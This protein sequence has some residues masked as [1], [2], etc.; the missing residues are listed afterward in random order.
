MFGFRI[1][2]S[3]TSSRRG[4]LSGLAATVLIGLM[5]VTGAAQAQVRQT[6][7]GPVKGFTFLGF[8]QFR[9][10]PYAAP[11]IGKLRWRPPALPVAWKGTRDAT[12]YGPACD[13]PYALDPTSEDC[14]TLN[15]YQPAGVS[16]SGKLPVMIWI[17][18][19]AFITG[20]GRDF[21]GSAL[22][23]HENLTVVTINY[24][25]GYLGFL[26][27]PALSAADRNHVSGNYGLLD[28]QAA[29]AWVR[30]N[31]AAFG[32]DPGHI[33]IFGES[34]G[35]Q[36]V[37][38]QLISPTAGPLSGAIAQSGSY[39][40]TLPTLAAAEVSGKTAATS[41]GCPSQSLSC[42]Y[43]L[44]ASAIAAALNPLSNAGVSPVVDGRTLLSGPAQ[45]FAQGKFQH[46]PVINGSTHDE[47]RLFTGIER[48]LGNTKPLT[49]TQYVSTVNG[50]F[51]ALAATVLKAYPS[52]SYAIPDYAYDAVLTDVAFVCNTHLL[53]TLMARYT[54][55]YEYELADPNAPVA[56]GPVVSGFSYGSPHSADIS[57]LF[58]GYNVAFFHPKG[59]PALSPNQQILR[60]AIQSYWGGM[61]RNG[62]PVNA[63]SAA[64]P[65]YS[66]ASP[67]VLR[68]TPPVGYATLRLVAD[69][70]C[71]F[72]KP[73]LLKEAGLPP[74]SPY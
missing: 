34:A 53:N 30:R 27:H 62:N 36:S 29:F 63:S 24:R 17:H 6:E 66:R 14:L 50:Q 15:I 49:A 2:N 40:T 60:T 8:T 31:I 74:N 73:T 21:D 48:L 45:A 12:D 38:D 71:E 4:V 10:I 25:L 39:M 28:Q 64:W 57:Y 41:L 69:H 1:G 13:Q 70:H 54:P 47:Y 23:V 37:I 19:G 52:K 67:I 16:T 3:G 22:A 59:P 33:T 61:A 26:A 55:V 32:G 9:D 44:S 65:A 56:S 42:L 46:I 5:T 18:G 68:L 7:S 11:P 35:G 20:S 72:W 58:P 43:A 51:G